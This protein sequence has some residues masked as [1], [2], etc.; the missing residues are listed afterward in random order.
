MAG[1]HQRA[2][3]THRF[4][5]TRDDCRELMFVD[6]Q[7]RLMSDICCWFKQIEFIAGALEDMESVL[8]AFQECS[9]LF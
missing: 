9:R 1:S 8:G 3:E 5:M 7:G 4:G 6:V 2:G